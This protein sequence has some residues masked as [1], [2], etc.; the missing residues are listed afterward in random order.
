MN[1]IRIGKENDLYNIAQLLVGTWKSCYKDF[2]PKSYLDKLDVERQFAR[3]Q[4]IMQKGTKYFICENLEGVLIGFASYG[5]S[6]TD[7][8][9]TNSDGELY[10]LYVHPNFHG[11]GIGKKLLNAVMTELDKSFVRLGVLVM[12]E[13]PFKAFYEKNGFSLHFKS[14]IDIGGFRVNSLI[15]VKSLIEK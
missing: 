6:R 15:Y 7:S 10:T 1:Q 2:L 9:D 3:H 4:K 12:E 14:D 13:N 11:K 8:L 5:K